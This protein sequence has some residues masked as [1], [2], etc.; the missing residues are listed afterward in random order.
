MIAT[1]MYMH[2]G[3]GETKTSTPDALISFWT[4]FNHESLVRNTK[5][6]CYLHWGQIVK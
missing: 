3:G 1:E 5:D 6:I 2:W 4:P